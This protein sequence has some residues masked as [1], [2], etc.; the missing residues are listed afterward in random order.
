MGKLNCWEFKK[1]GRQIGGEKAK[2]LGVCIAST[3]K[4]TDGV[5]NG[6]FAGRCCWA[7]A[8]TLCGGPVQGTFAQELHKCMDC[9]FYWIV[10]REEGKDAMSLNQILKLTQK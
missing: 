10:S 6:K 1:C 7:V 9:E 5:N 2:K 8:G 4:N 3:Q